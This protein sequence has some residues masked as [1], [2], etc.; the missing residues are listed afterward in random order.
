[1]GIKHSIAC[2][3]LVYGV[4][5]NDADYITQ[6]VVN[7]KQ[8]TC[9]FYRCWKSMLNRCYS[10]STQYCSP[11][12]EGCNVCDEWLNS[13]MAFREWMRAQEWE[14]KQ[15]DKD[16]IGDGKMYLPDNCLFVSQA[17]NSFFTDSGASRGEHP[18][19]V[20]WVKQSG[21]YKAQIRV[22]GK[23]KNLGFFTSPDEAH[24]AWYNAKLEIANGFLENESNPRIRYAIECGIAKLQCKYG[25]ALANGASK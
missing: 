1:M 20:Y 2:R 5:I 14:G 13:F 12:Y 22:N 25:S 11:T 9:S 8:I 15:L 21:K 18:I 7:G 4:G 24:A 23:Q 19:G 17:L 10:A 3:R 16:L 6:P